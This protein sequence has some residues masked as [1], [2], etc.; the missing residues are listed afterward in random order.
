MEN[1]ALDASLSESA[2]KLLKRH[3]GFDA[4]RSHQKPV[5]EEVIAGRDVLVLMPTGGGK[6]LCYQ[7]PALVR[8][9]VGIVVSP[10]IA[11]MEDQVSA[12]KALGIR[13]ECY[14][15]SQNSDDARS[16]LARLH[17][18]TLDLLYIAPERLLSPGFIERLHEC[19]IALFAI[20]EAHCVSQ[21]GHDFRPEYAELGALKRE[22]PTVP[23]IALTATA[24]RQTQR[25]ITERL[26][27]S[28]TFYVASFNRPNIHY[29]VVSKH[30][31][32]RQIEAFLK[33]HPDE[34]GI[35]YCSTRST[36]ERLSE[37]L[38]TR[39]FRARAY[40]A[41]LPHDERREVQH[42]FRHDKIDLVIATIAFGMGIDK[43]NVRFVIHHDIPKTIEGYYQETGRAGRDGLPSKA[44]LLYDPADSA[45]LRAFIAGIASL[46]VQRIESAKL[47]H[48]LAFAEASHCRRQILLRYFD[49]EAPEPCGHCDVCDHPPEKVDATVDAQKF[50][51][52][53]YRLGQ[54]YGMGY[55]IA[56]LRGSQSEKIEAAGHHVLST[57]GIGKDKPEHWWRQLAWQLIHEEY[58]EQ[59]INQYNILRLKKKAGLLLK[60]QATLMLA[61]RKEL[62]KADRKNAREKPAQASSPLFEALRAL[63]RRIA[64][65]ESKP[66]F[67]VFSDAS[68]FDMIA[69][70]P[71][72]LGAFLQVSGVGQSKLERYG[73]RFIEC[74]ACNE[75]A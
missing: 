72:T 25:D 42:L 26:N 63:R 24:D 62:P 43:P 22:F 40:H 45:K 41:G 4:F 16:V 60:G 61:V 70:K 48:M 74:I 27:F 36:V 14:N 11:L 15:S 29:Q 20:D 54:R 38:I 21:W 56:V 49:E 46:Q 32:L 8:Q 33:E 71:R 6:S 51:S 12:L 69:L 34:P 73:A 10:L 19:P 50:L 30:Q 55:T 5:I 2:L 23:M 18:G 66:P 39:N 52:C 44:L 3:W 35:I 53:V 13:A 28:P 59:D 58:C 17:A 9:G 68:L 7:L 57:Y 75:E 47:G 31:P 64:E 1:H 67:M 65:E 37:A